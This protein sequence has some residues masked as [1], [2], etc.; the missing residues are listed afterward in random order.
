[1]QRPG[2]EKAKDLVRM[3]V[4]KVSLFE[5]M[6]EPRI[7]INQTALVIGGGI[8]GMSAAKN[9][10]AQGYRTCLIEKEWR[11]GRPGSRYLSNLEG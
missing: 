6:S 3:A 7:K 1:M 4:G 8:S 11:L 10:A 9:L 5:P 2:T